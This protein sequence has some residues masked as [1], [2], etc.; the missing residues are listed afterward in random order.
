MVW[1]ARG[2]CIQTAFHYQFGS[3]GVVIHFEKI[4]PDPPTTT[5]NPDSAENGTEEEN[6]SEI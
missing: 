3:G 6:V 1:G 2:C 4:G 5:R